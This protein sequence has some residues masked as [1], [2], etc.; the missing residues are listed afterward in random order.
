MLELKIVDGAVL[1]PV[2]V[3][4]GAS[5]TRLLGEW[6]GRARIAV[7]AA[8]EHGKANAALTAYLAKLLKVPRR[9]IEVVAGHTQPLKTVRIEAVVEETVRRV[10]EQPSEPER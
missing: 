7:A 9:S 8:P 2:K 5:R 4:P 10:L 1:L 3:V 6:S